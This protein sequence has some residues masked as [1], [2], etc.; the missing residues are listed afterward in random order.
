[1]NDFLSAVSDYLHDHW[2]KF[3]TAGGFMAV[4][5]VLGKRRARSEWRKKE[6][7]SRLN[8]SLNV[9][10]DGKLM[11]RTI[12]EKSCDEI[13]LNSVA[14][15]TVMT[16]ARKTTPD[17]PILPLP[18]KEYWYYLN[19]V[20]NEVSEKF[21]LGQ[22]K[23]DVGQPVEKCLYLLCLTCECSGE[24]KTRKVR[25]MLVRKATL[26][27]LPAEQPQLESPTHATRFKTLHQLAAAWRAAPHRFLEMEICV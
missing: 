26:E 1:M 14:V 13:F 22:M 19:A 2:I 12:I 3:V 20:L 9:L 8:I 15:D 4:G 16:A 17:D 7:L 23:R 24:M 27:N 11:I 6:F 25:A 21:A 5:W 18:E 10:R